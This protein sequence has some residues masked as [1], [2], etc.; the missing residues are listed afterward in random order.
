MSSPIQIT[1]ADYQV[2][3]VEDHYHQL[4]IQPPAGYEGGSI[5]D[6]NFYS[7]TA[8]DFTHYRVFNQKISVLRPELADAIWESVRM[9]IR[10]IVAAGTEWEPGHPTMPLIIPEEKLREIGLI[11]PE[12]PPLHCLSL[13]LLKAP[14]DLEEIVNWV[15]MW[16]QIGRKLTAWVLKAKEVCAEIPDTTWKWIP[17][18][19]ARVDIRGI[20]YHM[21]V[22][23][24]DDDEEE[25][26]ENEG[27]PGMHTAYMH[28][29]LQLFQLLGEYYNWWTS[30][31]TTSHCFGVS[32][33]L[34][35]KRPD[36]EEIKETGPRYHH[37][38]LIKWEPSVAQQFENQKGL[39]YP[40]YIPTNALIQQPYEPEESVSGDY[41]IYSY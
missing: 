6:L 38:Q 40:F 7:P 30:P 28:I 4:P 18:N 37:L 25:F 29:F 26:V 17:T 13:N 27:E 2:R 20:S 21:Q 33:S 31:S 1:S 11:H 34:K 23:Y 35:R 3:Q 5:F 16:Q 12:F 15:D 36:D 9:K 22:E 24:P 39:G 8:R 41:G 19:R 14:N 32:T 10:E